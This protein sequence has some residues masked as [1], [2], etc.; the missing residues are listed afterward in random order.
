M[1][2]VLQNL[3]FEAFVNLTFF[4]LATDNSAVDIF[5]LFYNSWYFC[6]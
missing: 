5:N 2:L 6:L 4:K 3:F 1:T